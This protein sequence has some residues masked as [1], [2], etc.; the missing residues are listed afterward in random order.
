MLALNLTELPINVCV[1]FR[2][3]G[4]VPSC[5][6]RDVEDPGHDAGS[7]DPGNPS[8]CA[9]NEALVCGCRRIQGRIVGVYH[10]EERRKL[11]GNL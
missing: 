7:L 9:E 4:D 1:Y 5:I 10:A 8:L 3:S 2:N 6:L 11:D